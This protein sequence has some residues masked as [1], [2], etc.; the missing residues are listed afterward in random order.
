MRPPICAICDK[1]F[2]INERAG[3]VSFETTADDEK[4]YKKAS[5]PGFVGHPPNQDWFCAEHYQAAQACNTKRC[6]RL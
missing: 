6:L 5:E 3:L 2:E 1:D 4:W